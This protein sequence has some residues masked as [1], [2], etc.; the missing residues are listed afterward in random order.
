MLILGQYL[1]NII[2]KCNLFII[3][4]IVRSVLRVSSCQQQQVS[5]WHVIRSKH[6]AGKLHGHLAN[7]YFRL[8]RSRI[9]SKF[10]FIVF[11]FELLLLQKPAH[12]CN[13][14]SH[15]SL[16]EVQLGPLQVGISGNHH[17]QSLLDGKTDVSLLL[18][19]D[20]WKD[21]QSHFQ[22]EYYRVTNERFDFQWNNETLRV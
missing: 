18:K 11:S 14:C 15:Q 16:H 20:G 10:S 19:V 8:H 6:C 12:F 4:I 1:I 5:G 3:T 17:G 13:V 2:C 21:E 22:C 7:L 9:I